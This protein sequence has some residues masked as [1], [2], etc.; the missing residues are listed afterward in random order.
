MWQGTEEGLQP[1][2]S[3]RLRSS[4]QMI[5]FTSLKLI[6]CAMEDTTEGMKRQDAD[7]QKTFASHIP[8]KELVSRI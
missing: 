8:N 7:G 2:A 5:N 4:D 3:K 1:I 6:H